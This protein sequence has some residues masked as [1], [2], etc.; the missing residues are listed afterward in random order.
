MQ[1]DGRETEG[2]LLTSDKADFRAKSITRD[3]G[4]HF[5][6]KSDFLDA[7]LEKHNP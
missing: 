4:G 1:T 5:M 3:N 7:T 6:I 2:Q